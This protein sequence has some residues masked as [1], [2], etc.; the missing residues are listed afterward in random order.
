MRSLAIL[1]ITLFF[2][3]A[4]WARDLPRYAIIL[5]DPAPI[6][7]RPQGG[8][9]A[10]VAARARLLPRQESMK[11]ELRRRGIRITGSSHI[12]LNA[13]FVAAEPDQADQLK[14]LAGVMHVAPL[15]R[16]HLNLDHAEQLINVPAAWNLLGGTS[17]AGA[18]VKIGFIDSGIEA[19]HPAFQD[20]SLT[21][22]SGFPVC[23]VVFPGA[24]L[25]QSIDCTATDPA[26]GFPLCTAGTCSYTNNKVIVARSYVP[27]LSSGDAAS[28][29][30][31]D[32]S[33]EDRVG[34]GTAVAMAAAGVTVTGPADTITGVAPKAFIGS[35]KVF[36]SSSV[37][38]FTTGDVV[39]Q[40]LEDAYSDGMDIV[41][42]SL[43]GPAL[44]GPLDTGKTCGL[45]LGQL[46]DPEAY[47][48]HHAVVDAGM[49]VVAAAGNEG[50]TGL[51][52]QP[53]LST[54]DSPGDA[55]AAIAVAATT[56]SHSWG[57]TL[58]VSGLAA[59]HARLSDGPPPAATVTGPLG[60]VASVGD[61]QACSAPPAGSLAGL[62][63][64]VARGTCTFAVKIQNLQA[65]GAVGAI[66]TNSAGDDTLVT[67]SGLGGTT[68]P[69]I[70]VGYDDGAAIRT[71]LTTNPKAAVSISPNF[72]AFDITTFNQVAP[73]SSHGPVVGTSA[74]KPD[75]AAVGVDLYLAGET[76]DPNGELYSA[77][78][79]LV[80]Q[81]TSFST[82]QVAGI[83]ALVKQTYPLLPALELKS[84][85]VNTATQDVTE[86][87]L[88]ASVLA[89]GAGKA[90]AAF[91]VQNTLTVIPASA[92]F[93]VLPG[94]P[95][96]LTQQFQ[97][98]NIGTTPLNLSVSLTR[99]TPE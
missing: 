18:G 29:R 4:A 71:F 49:L 8:R 73:F 69:S 12:L 39:I 95:L 36:G 28:S 72:G 32:P 2:S 43:G 80:S 34:H 89:V 65:A 46:C 77:N 61:P 53:G 24:A 23:Q 5:S 25:D 74:L 66:I 88:P 35:Y 96:P 82:P 83:A 63:A 78:G 22:P 70:F 98:H 68:I 48:V 42:L 56:N 76:F 3:L 57:N 60:D 19:T 31:D 55:P 92:S 75:I 21:P 79:F 20:P 52:L 87:G 67:A 86:N 11:A 90:N 38:D 33:P 27:L 15:A 30:P 6:T 41:V 40:A 7:A 17:N 10:V 14:S 13:I 54:I 62:I 91:A 64:L 51:P 93:G 1:S 45:S 9:T 94:T 47:V 99:R 85:V 58:T 44:Y 16:Y 97:L 26:K 84:A 59:Y 50:Q 81:G 37:N